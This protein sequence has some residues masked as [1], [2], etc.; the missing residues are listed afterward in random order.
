M[1]ITTA[2]IEVPVTSC[3]RTEDGVIDH[4]CFLCDELVGYDYQY[5]P[6]PHN[7]NECLLRLKERID[8]LFRVQPQ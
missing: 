7:L 4:F 5:Q 6:Q 2:D 3:K 1:P 8:G